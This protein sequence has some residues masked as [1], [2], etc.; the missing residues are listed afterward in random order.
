MQPHP[1]QLPTDDASRPVPKRLRKGMLLFLL[2]IAVAAALIA[3]AFPRMQGKAAQGPASAQP[4][5]PRAQQA[6]AD[7]YKS[8]AAK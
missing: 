6:Q 3:Y 2:A 4:A 1:P 5:T 8:P 7:A